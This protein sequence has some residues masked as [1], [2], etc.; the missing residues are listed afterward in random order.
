M[1]NKRLLSLAVA[2]L[3][4]LGLSGL[5]AAGIPDDTLSTVSSGSGTLLVTPQGTGQTLA[6]QG[7]T[8]FLTVRDTGGAP[9]N[10]YPFQDMWVDDSGDGSIALC[11]GGSLADGSTNTAGATTFS[12]AFSAGGFTQAGLQVYLAGTPVVGGGSNGVL[13]IDVNSPDIT[14]D[15]RVNLADVG[16]FGID[17]GGAYNFRS[18][19]QSDGVINLADVGELGIHNGEVCP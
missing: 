6:A 12:G 17:F 11:Q 1:I 4:V 9:I 8:I 3:M 10:L 16:E 19:F 5:A 13:A 15:L 7:V 18:D 14:G 2:G